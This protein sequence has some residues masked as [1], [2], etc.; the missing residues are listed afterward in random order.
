MDHGGNFMAAAKAYGFDY[1]EIIDLSTGIAPYA[2]PLD[3]IDMS[4]QHWRDLPQMETEQ[5]LIA[6]MKAYWG[7][8]SS[9]GLLLTPG[10]GVV[11]SLAALL[12]PQTTVLC[13]DPSYSEH[14]IAWTHHGHRIKHYPAGAIPQLTAEAQADAQA[15]AK[16]VITVQ[17]GNPTGHIHPPEDW[18]FVID[19]MAERDGL[20][21]VDEAF[22]DLMPEFSMASRAG[23]KGLLVIRSFGK[24]YGLAGLRLGAVMG[25]DDDITRLRQ[26]LGPWAVST[27]ALEIGLK[28]ISDHAWAD[29][30]RQVLAQNMARLNAMLIEVGL[31]PCGGTDLYSLINL[32]DAKTLHDHLAKHGIWTRIFDY[33]PHWMRFGLPADEGQW[34]RLQSALQAW[35]QD[36]N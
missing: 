15:D 26:M 28:A 32:D 20:L 3:G 2:Y 21:I 31:T 27:P 14:E 29:E 36:G 7:C 25:H 9:A 23:R 11:I 24:F 17:P 12:R 6:A 22:I 5:A 19:Q 30:Q 35:R 18:D 10:S 4:G 1:A 34:Q 16:V 13:P 8:D 33:N